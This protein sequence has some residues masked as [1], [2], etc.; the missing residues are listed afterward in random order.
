MAKCFCGCQ[1]DIRFGQRGVNKQGKRTVELLGKLET[2][3]EGFSHKD[4]LAQAVSDEKLSEVLEQVD[5][6]I[7]EGRE[8]ASFWQH[9]VHT[10]EMP[11]PKEALQIKRAWTQWGKG[12]RYAVSALTPLIEQ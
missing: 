8:Y 9:V 3:Q 6:A 12:G 10:D 11:P 7:R 1:R 2:L 5:D 4:G